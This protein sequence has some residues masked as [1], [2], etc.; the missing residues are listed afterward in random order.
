[1][2]FAEQTSLVNACFAV[3]CASCGKTTWKVSTPFEGSFP[4][5]SGSLMPH[6]LPSRSVPELRG[7]QARGGCGGS[8][9][10]MCFL[11]PLSIA[12]A[13]VLIAAC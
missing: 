11:R 4:R 1:M 2:A 7:H 5:A 3:K 8:K 12:S 6:T 10:R 13:A 9:H